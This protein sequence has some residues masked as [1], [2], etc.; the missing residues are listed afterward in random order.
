VATADGTSVTDGV[1]KIVTA[2]PRVVGVGDS[3]FGNMPCQTYR[4]I[5]S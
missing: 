2:D 1:A 4:W 5:E 3:L